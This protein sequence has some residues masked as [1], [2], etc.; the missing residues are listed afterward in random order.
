MVQECFRH[1]KAIGTWGDGSQAFTA[2]GVEESAA[3]V[4][5]GDAAGEVLSEVTGLLAE[6]RVWNRSG[7]G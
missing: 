4:V 5:T 7:A 6:H 1:A 2:S 3:G